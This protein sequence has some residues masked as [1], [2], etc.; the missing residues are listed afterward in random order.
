MKYYNHNTDYATTFNEMNNPEVET[1]K[2][3]RLFNYI[4]C[5]LTLIVVIVF[6]GLLFFYPDHNAGYVS[7]TKT[8]VVNYMSD[9][10]FLE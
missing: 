7:N 2:L 6:F 5:C 3:E 8:T 4:V 1:R 10:M 9:Q